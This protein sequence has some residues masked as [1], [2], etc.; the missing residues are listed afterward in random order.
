MKDSVRKL[1]QTHYGLK[2][3][4]KAEVVRSNR[5]H[6]QSLLTRSAFHF[7]VTPP[8]DNEQ[9]T[10]CISADSERC[11]SLLRAPHR[12]RHHFQHVVLEWP[13]ELW[14]E[15]RRVLQPNRT[16]NACF[17]DDDRK[18]CVSPVPM[19]VPHAQ[20]RS[21]SVSTSGRLECSFP[22]NFKSRAS[23]VNSP[24]TS[25]AHSVGIGSNPR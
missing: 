11:P 25:R 1:V 15:A 19:P 21:N 14:G 10:D 7:K 4:G 5:E 17:A 2:P 18:S 24:A 3:G 20:N 22:T 16:P 9:A 12:P 23:R 13:R 8:S 6:I